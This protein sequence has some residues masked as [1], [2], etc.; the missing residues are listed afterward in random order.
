M[1]QKGIWEGAAEIMPL[2][3]GQKIE[4]VLGSLVEKSSLFIKQLL[5][6]LNLSLLVCEMVLYQ[7]EGREAK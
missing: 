5:G 6:A 3:G 1:L 2:K 4:Q 7:R